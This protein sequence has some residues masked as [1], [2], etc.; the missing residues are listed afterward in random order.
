[1]ARQQDTTMQGI[2]EQALDQFERN[3]MLS[4][5]VSAYADLE[6]DVAARQEYQAAQALYDHALMD[7]LENLDDDDALDTMYLETTGNPRRPH[8]VRTG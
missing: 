2:L 4:E 1:L 7:G 8:P 3:L 6:S 5:T